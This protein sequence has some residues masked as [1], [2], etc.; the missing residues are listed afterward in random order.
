MK[1]SF[2]LA[3]VFV[4][5]AS[6]FIAYPSADSYAKD[7]VFKD[8]KS[9][10][11]Y[12]ESVLSLSERGIINGFNDGTFKPNQAVTR[13]QAAKILAHVLE[14]DLE[15]V[16]DPK[17]LDVKPSHPFYKEIVALAN[18]GVISG[19]ADDTYRSDQTLSR[20]QM[21]KII[22]EGFHFDVRKVEK[23]PF[24]DVKKTVWYANYVQTLVAHNITTGITATSFGPDHAV[25]R[26]QIATFITRSEKAAGLFEPDVIAG[27]GDFDALDGN[28]MNASFRSPASLV[29]LA[30][31]AVLISDRQNQL[32]RKLQDGIV[33][34]FAGTTFELNNFGYPEGGLHDAMKETA[35]FNDPS[36]MV[37]DREGNIYIAD[38]SNHVIRKIAKNGEVTTIAGD[39]LP[40][41]E[42]GIGENA[43]FNHPQ[44]VAIAA[45]GTLYVADTLNH[46]IRKID[47]NGNVTTLNAPSLRPVEVT[48]GDIENAGDL[49]DG[50]LKTAKFNE[51]SGLAIDSK[52]NLYVSDT[53]NQLI[54]YIN[55][56]TNTVKTV[57]GK[58]VNN[59]T[60]Y[61][62]GGYRDGV[63][64]EALFHSPS[65]MTVTKEGGVVIAD[66]LNHSVRYLLN[67]KVTTLV[68]NGLSHPTDV[69]IQDGMILIVDS[70][71]NQIRQ[72]QFK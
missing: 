61:A 47:P 48:D 71:H 51:P 53:G 2:R 50:D 22:A 56:A 15:S 33:S 46:L 6:F 8:I 38:A 28:A 1:R 40:G 57:A 35:V 41:D 63:A 20:A 67:G 36:G 54:R 34:T 29:A 13:G 25:T 60:L 65:G 24:T 64:L 9:G 69:A 55:F 10:S 39:G 32:I 18:A 31:G 17:F 30:D 37:A 72:I 12:Y 26:A 70:Y 52:G 42:D 21:A 27:N 43:R 4:F 45:N 23:L 16:K 49:Q 58:S 7:N 14:L 66:R 11:Y 62:N 44:D 3:I 68:K 19:F 59:G 5:V